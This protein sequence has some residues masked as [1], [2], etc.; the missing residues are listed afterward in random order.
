ML[1]VRA[2]R[3]VTSGNVHADTGRHSRALWGGERLRR[4]D[5]RSVAVAGQDKADHLAGGV[6]C[7][8]R[9]RSKVSGLGGGSKKTVT[10]SSKFTPYAY[11]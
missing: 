2:A 4:P 7:L 6:G 8:D 11:A 3:L 10:R 9:P 1:D 5:R